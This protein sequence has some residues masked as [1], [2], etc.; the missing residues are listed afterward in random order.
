MQE[1]QEMPVRSL[2]GEDPLEEEMA[3]H[4]SIL[5]WKIPWTE[6]PGRLQS[7]GSQ[8]VGHDW[9]TEHARSGNTRQSSSSWSVG[10]L[11]FPVLLLVSGLV[12]VFDASLGC[13]LAQL[14]RAGLNEVK[15]G[16]A[17]GSSAT[18]KHS[19]RG[20]SSL[21][22]FPRWTFGGEEKRLIQVASRNIHRKPGRLAR[23]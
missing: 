4:S 13:S 11:R 2:A 15:S 1:I 14:C 19:L 22:K 7:K 9:V 23:S 20:K 3:T 5:A 21:G 6:E 10:V 18:E 12:P 16:V 17:G 8:R